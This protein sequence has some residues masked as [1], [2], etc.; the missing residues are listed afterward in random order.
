V[1]KITVVTADC[2]GCSVLSKEDGLRVVLIGDYGT[3]CQTNALDNVEVRDYTA[4]NTAVFDGEPEL[5]GDDDGL[6]HCKDVRGKSNKI[7]NIFIFLVKADLNLFLNGGSAT[8][9]GSGV[10]T[11]STSQPICIN[12]YDPDK[13]KPT[14]CCHLAT[15]SLATDESTD[16]VDCQCSVK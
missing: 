5:D 1:T 14:C 13:V 16:L 9:T 4:G 10:W 15:L 11:G 2:Q 12:F 3:E 6:G 8:W 7:F